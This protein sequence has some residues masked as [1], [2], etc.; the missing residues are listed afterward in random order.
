MRATTVNRTASVLLALLATLGTAYAAGRV[1]NRG[2]VG[3][4]IR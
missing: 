1:R 4:F 2:L 3:R